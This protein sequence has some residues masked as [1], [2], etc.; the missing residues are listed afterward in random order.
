MP[1]VRAQPDLF[2]P[3]AVNVPIARRDA[4]NYRCINSDDCAWEEYRSDRRWW[5]EISV[6]RTRK[7]YFYS[8]GCDYGA[9]GWRG[10]IF[11]AGNPLP[12]FRTARQAALDELAEKIRGIQTNVDAG[13]VEKNRAAILKK[14][15]EIR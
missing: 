11:L 1:K 10:P 9:G 14:I 15:G 7:G 5:F 3:N 8:H 13:L 4:R 6:G 12:S 2:G